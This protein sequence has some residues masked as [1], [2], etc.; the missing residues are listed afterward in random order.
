MLESYVPFVIFGTLSQSHLVDIP[1]IGFRSEIQH[2]APSSAPSIG[3]TPH[4]IRQLYTQ[5]WS[6]AGGSGRLPISQPLATFWAQGDE[7]THPWLP[8][9]QKGRLLSRLLRIPWC[10]IF[11]NAVSFR[12]PIAACLQRLL[13]TII[14]STIIIH[15]PRRVTAPGKRTSPRI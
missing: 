5:L 15:L 3:T 14:K 4:S 12:I 9:L 7:R 10:S 8:E 2:Q 11:V 1:L 6:F 13:S